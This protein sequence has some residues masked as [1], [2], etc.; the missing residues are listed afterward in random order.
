MICAVLGDCVAEAIEIGI[1]LFQTIEIGEATAQ[2]SQSIAGLRFE[3]VSIIVEFA[4]TVSDASAEVFELFLQT[5]RSATGVLAE[6]PILTLEFPI[7]GGHSAFIV[8]FQFVEIGLRLVQEAKVF[9]EIGLALLFY[10]SNAVKVGVEAV[11][12]ASKIVGQQGLKTSDVANS[13]F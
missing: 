1:P 3:V 5:G 4:E 11:L 8:K 9:I 2:S 12:V 10:V 6:S 13:A 7:E